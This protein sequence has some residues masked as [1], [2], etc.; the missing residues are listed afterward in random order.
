MIMAGTHFLGQAPYTDVFVTGMIKDKEGRWM[1]KSLGNGIDPLDMIEQY[2]A[3]AVRFTLAKLCAQG[4]DI[5]LDPT[6]FEGGRNFANKVWNAF[7][8]F[9]RFLETDETGRPTAEHGRQRA[10]ADLSLVETWLLTRLAETVH[11]V[12]EALDKYRVSEAA[13]LVYDFVWRDFCDWYLELAKPAHG[14]DGQPSEMDAETLA[15]SVE[16][17]DAILRLLHPFMPFLTEE[18][19]WKLRPHA[20]DD[21]LVVA[22][23]PAADDL[24]T[25]VEEEALFETVQALVVAVRQVRAQYN[26]PPSREIAARVRV[27]GDVPA[28]TAREIASA[29]AYVERAG[30]RRRPA[31]RGGPRE[32]AGERGRRR[33]PARGVRPPGGDDRPRPG[34]RAAG[35]GD[36]RE[37][38]VPRGRREK[39]PQRGVRHARARGRRGE[40]AAEG[41]GRPGRDRRAR[42]EPRRPG[43]DLG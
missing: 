5:K 26:V 21:A 23:W 14:A 30:G 25:D 18:L 39:A 6:T 24:H 28:E 32:A 8:V 3:D 31:D 29:S 36:R 33:G 17:F 9:G 40:G 22:P 10:F 27:G 35:E 42:G 13:Q 15:F 7:N 41:G 43:V 2:G 1:S 4:Q 37:A 19:W 16:T 38:P 12:D 20:P 34:A 11:A